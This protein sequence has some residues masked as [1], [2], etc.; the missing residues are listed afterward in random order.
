MGGIWM[1]HCETPWRTYKVPLRNVYLRIKK[2]IT[3]LHAADFIPQGFIAQM[4]LTTY[5]QLSHLPVSTSKPTRKTE[6][7]KLGASSVN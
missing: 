1:Y 3:S 5:E 7:E 2:A 6:D 4:Y